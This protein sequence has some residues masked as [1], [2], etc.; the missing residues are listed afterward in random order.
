MSSMRVGFRFRFAGWVQAGLRYH[1][2]WAPALFATFFV[3]APGDLAFLND[4]ISRSY[5]YLRLQPGTPNL[6]EGWEEAPR[7]L[8]RVV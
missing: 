4:A 2:G 6:V 7:R 5:P 3:R 1:T 8:D